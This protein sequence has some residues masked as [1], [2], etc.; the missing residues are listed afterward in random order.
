M[1]L[2]DAV[3]LHIDAMPDDVKLSFYKEKAIV[4]GYCDADGEIDPTCVWDNGTTH[5]CVYADR[6]IKKID[7]KHWI[8]VNH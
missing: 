6:G 1:K 5:D 4:S 2:I 7:C 3:E 8:K